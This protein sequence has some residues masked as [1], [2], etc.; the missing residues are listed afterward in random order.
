MNLDQINSALTDKFQV[1]CRDGAKRHIIFWYDPEGDFQEIVDELE[2]P[3]VKLWKLTETNKFLSK[4]TLEVLDTNS[5]Y[6]IYAAFAKPDDLDNWLLDIVLYSHT[7]IAD[8]IALMMDDLHVEHSGLRPFFKHYE[9]FFQSKERYAR[10]ASFSLEA[11]AEES[12]N[13]GVLSALAKRSTPDFEDALRVILMNSLQ[14]DENNVWQNIVKYGVVDGFWNLTEKYYGYFAPEKSLKS[15]LTFFI[16]NAL[17]SVLNRILPMEWQGLVSPRRANCVVFLDHFMH[18]SVDYKVYDKLA[19]EIEADLH[20]GEYLEQWDIQDYEQVDLFRAVDRSIILKLTNSLLI[21]SEEFA[22]YKEIVSLRKTKHYYPE[23]ENYYEAITWAIEMHAFKKKYS[24]GIPQRNALTFFE[25]YTKEYF[26]MDQAYRK[27]CASFDKERQSDVLKPLSAEIEN[28]YTNWYHTELAIK[29]SSTVAEEMLT[30]WPIQGIPQQQGFFQDTIQKAVYNNKK[31]FVII[32]DALRFE[33]AEDLMQRLN[34]EIEGSTELRWMQGCVPS[35]TRLGM[36]SLL[37]HK[38]LTMQGDDIL[39]DGVS[40]KDTSGRRK[41]L[42]S[43]VTDSDVVLLNDLIPMTRPE[44][45]NTFKGKNV[46]YI[47][48]NAIDSVGDKGDESKTFQAVEQAFD[49]IQGVIKTIN[50]NLTEAN[51]Y[52]TSD[53]GFIYRRKP[54]EESDKTS[55]GDTLPLYTNKRFLIF[56][57]AVDLPGSINLPLDD[58]FG[59]DCGLT[60]CVPRGDNRFKTPGGGQ[61]FVH[62]G[63]SL[64]EIV[65]PLIKYRNDRKKD[66]RMLISKVDIKLTNTS[67]KITNSLFSLDFFQTEKLVDKKVARTVKL[68][69]TDESGQKISNEQSILADRISEK[70]SERTFKASFNLKS[71]HYSRTDKYYLVLEDIEEPIKKMY[72]KIPF[73]ISL[74]IVNEFDF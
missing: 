4:Y 8:K 53:H 42:K 54:L 12:I 65:I 37:P 14:E 67:R 70:A 24:S 2:L 7:F 68:Y 52:I 55:K 13:I 10:F 63:A 3:E 1:P 25:A 36:A 48:H 26:I 30:S 62:G 71:S 50:K 19:E 11:Y 74:G 20:L 56:D 27:F 9:K 15:L 31:S 17:S 38:A 41:I 22:Q 45:R 57:Q 39:I 34:T 58:I 29:W 16:I 61:N 46:V 72:D 32:S 23:F 21:G 6:L 40:T 49:E 28:L 33:A 69:F 18:H 47:Y 73:S 59:K 5:H 60:V 66:E 35:Y 44:L 64:Q 43:N 51:I